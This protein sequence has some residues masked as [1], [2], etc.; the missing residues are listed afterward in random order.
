MTSK[1]RYSGKYED[2]IPNKR[3]MY[4]IEVYNNFIGYFQRRIDQ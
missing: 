1:V 2:I 4:Y 3:G